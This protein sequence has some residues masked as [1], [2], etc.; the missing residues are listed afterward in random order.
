MIKEG[1]EE[2]DVQRTLIDSLSLG[3]QRRIISICPKSLP[4]SFDL[5]SP[6]PKMEGYRTL[7]VNVGISLKG[8]DV[9]GLQEKKPRSLED[10]TISFKQSI[11][12]IDDQIAP[13]GQSLQMFKE[14][15]E[16]ATLLNGKQIMALEEISKLVKVLE[17]SL[18]FIR[19]AAKIVLFLNAYF[20]IMLAG[21]FLKKAPLKNLLWRQV[22]LICGFGC[23][24]FLDNLLQVALR[25]R[26]EEI[27][28]N[29]LN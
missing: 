12:A 13:W 11:K 22:R 29:K 24:R 4:F 1:L 21:A 10:A 2:Y 6:S 14:E 3:L 25:D 18:P 28:K 16:R 19:I 5:C 20:L 17:A 8:R 23:L 26:V 7:V 27:I 9:I 15:K